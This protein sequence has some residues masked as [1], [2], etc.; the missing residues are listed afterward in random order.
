MAEEDEIEIPPAKC[1]TRT[2][3]AEEASSFK[4]NSVDKLDFMWKMW[5]D[6][7]NE[8]IDILTK[9]NRELRTL[10]GIWTHG[11]GRIADASKASHPLHHRGYHA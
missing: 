9:E 10:L 2:A 7:T 6:G 1:I 3:P 8:M 11:H 5:K 4:W